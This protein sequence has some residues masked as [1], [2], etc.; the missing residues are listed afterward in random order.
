MEKKRLAVIGYGGMGGWHV[1]KAQDSDVVTLAGIYDILPERRQAAR[2]AG[3]F[4]YDSFEDVLADGGV[5]ILT[6]AVPND[7]H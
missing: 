5:D 6:L 3:I 7:C 4:A 2:E 1:R